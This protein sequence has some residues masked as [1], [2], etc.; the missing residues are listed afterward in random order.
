MVTFL[1]FV[2]LLGISPSCIVAALDA[3]TFEFDGALAAAAPTFEGAATDGIFDALAAAA[4]GAATDGIFDALAAAATF[5]SFK[6][7]VVASK[8][9]TIFL[10]HSSLGLSCLRTSKSLY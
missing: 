1:T 2:A 8:Q 6:N 3:A 7:P 4:F 9:S 5:G 10:M